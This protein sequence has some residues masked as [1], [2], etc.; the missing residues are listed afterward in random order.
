MDTSAF[1]G[2]LAYKIRD[3]SCGH[4]VDGGD[5]RNKIDYTKSPNKQTDKH[6]Y[7]YQG[8]IKELIDAEIARGCLIMH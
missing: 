3:I 7:C 2:P 5:F 8:K 4:I 1:S 6:N